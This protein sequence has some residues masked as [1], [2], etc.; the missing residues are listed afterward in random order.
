M[1]FLCLRKEF[2]R[3]V[4]SEEDMVDSGGNFD[5]QPFAEFL[6]LQIHVFDA[7]LDLDL[8]EELGESIRLNDFVADSANC[9]RPRIRPSTS[10]L[11]AP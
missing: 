6:V 4:L 11:T 1:R 3:V 9:Q 2:W 8:F 10:G 7:R 5:A